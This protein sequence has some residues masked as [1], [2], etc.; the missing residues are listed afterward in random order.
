MR[1][2]E[3]VEPSRGYRQDLFAANGK[4]SSNL[5]LPRRP[6]TSFHPTFPFTLN[7]CEPARS[8]E[9]QSDTQ[10][11]RLNS[12]SNSPGAFLII[13][14]SKNQALN[15]D[16][17]LRTSLRN[18]RRMMVRWENDSKSKIPPRDRGRLKSQHTPRIAPGNDPQDKILREGQIQREP[19]VYGTACSAAWLEGEH[20]FFI[21]ATHT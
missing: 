21:S 12:S 15:Q 8:S 16:S 11:S 14:L 18:S 5:A 2:D 3:F 7:E 9:S 13:A 6:L 4:G 10:S 20:E 19:N 1:K 17:S